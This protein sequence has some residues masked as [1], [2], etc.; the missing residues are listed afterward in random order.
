VTIHYKSG[1]KVKVPNQFTRPG[2]PKV[3]ATVLKADPPWVWVRFFFNG[4]WRNSKHR[5][6][7]VKE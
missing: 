6:E 4:K 5:M 3:E 1:D 7:E 2:E